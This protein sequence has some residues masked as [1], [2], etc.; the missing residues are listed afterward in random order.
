MKDLTEGNVF[1]HIVYFSVPMLLGNVFQQLYN[2]ADSLIVGRFIGKE[3]LAAVGASFPLLFI[4]TSLIIGL[5]MGMSVVISQYYGAKD[6]K[7]VTLAIDS[8]ILFIIVSGIVVGLLGYFSCNYLF[9]LLSIPNDVIDGA[10]LYFKILIAGIIFMFAYNGISSIL[11]ALGDSKTPLYFLIISTFLN[12]ILD[13]V[14]IVVFK[15]GIGAVAVATLISQAVATLGLIVYINKKHTLIKIKFRNWLFDKSIFINSVKIGLP[16]GIQQSVVSLSMVLILSLVSSFGTD[17]LAGY[18]I[19]L[20]IDAFAMMPIMTIS[21]ALTS[22]VGQNIGAGRLD[23]V[24]SGYIS[25]LLL[26]IS[27]SAILGVIFI[28]W[29]KFLSG[30]FTKDVEV[31][32]VSAQYLSTIG[33]FFVFLAGVFMTNGLMRG[34]GDSFVPML[35]IVVSQV[36]VRVP[37][38]YF[39]ASDTFHLGSRGIWWGQPVA[40]IVGFVLTF[41]YYKSGRWKTKSVVVQPD[42]S[43]VES[44]SVL[45]DD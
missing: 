16:H 23:R 4:L 20:R 29:G 40:W 22:F 37:V 41:F 13:I 1:K 32:S 45:V 44:L 19:A 27:T 35:L 26:S 39:F 3:A 24:R 12:I 7:K 18:S 8:M 17:T 38:S 5:T 42:V 31:I 14:F 2:V 15:W 30:F 36:L 28:F 21:L 6:I 43:K 25:A 10:T 11:R 33:G 34:A 9:N